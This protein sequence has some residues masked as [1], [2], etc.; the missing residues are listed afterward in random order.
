MTEFFGLSKVEGWIKEHKRLKPHIRT[1]TR[2]SLSLIRRHV[3]NRRAANQI[4]VSTSSKRQNTPPGSSGKHFRGQTSDSRL[5]RIHANQKGADTRAHILGGPDSCS[6]S[7]MRSTP[8][9]LFTP[10]AIPLPLP[11]FAF[12]IFRIARAETFRLPLN[13]EGI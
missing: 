8:S 10:P 1:V 7:H 4:R 13:R 9:A 5:C 3:A 6:S 11:G 12:P 2:H